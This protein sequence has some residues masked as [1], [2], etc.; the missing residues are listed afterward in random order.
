MNQVG[1][2]LVWVILLMSLVFMAFTITVYTTHHNWK[3][4]A[5]ELNTQL[6]AA[7]D[8]NNSLSR[9]KEELLKLHEEYVARSQQEVQKLSAETTLTKEEI[10]KL[11]ADA[12]ELNKSTEQAIS[13]LDSVHKNLAKDRAEIE[14]LRTD[15]DE[16]MRSRNDL[17]AQV[18]AATD[19]GH[20]YALNYA[21]LMQTNKRLAND[22]ADALTVLNVLG[23]SPNPD[24]HLGEAP[25]HIIGE[26]TEV[27]PTGMVAVSIGADSGLE[28]GHRLH[29]YHEDTYLGQI[30]IIKTEPNQAAA[31]ILPE[32][33]T[34]TIQRGDHVATKLY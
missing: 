19:Q 2:I 24:R 25:A 1:K 13:T 4:R 3:V 32:F 8:K 15:F 31:K 29:V 10:A 14:K 21:T 5:D 30:E 23:E 18:I 33:R 7:Q 12:N 26:I 28:K 34:G 17:L 9:E 27:R 11:E 6:K 20:T 22:L 16:S